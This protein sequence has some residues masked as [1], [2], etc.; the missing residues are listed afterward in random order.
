MWLQKWSKLRVVFY[1]NFESSKLEPGRLVT[2]GMGSQD[3]PC[4]VYLDRYLPC[5]AEHLDYLLI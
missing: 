5:N 2:S 1:I 4:T 3:L